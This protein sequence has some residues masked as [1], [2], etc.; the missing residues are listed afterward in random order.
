M[1]LQRLKDSGGETTCPL[2]VEFIDIFQYQ[3]G[4]SATGKNGCDQM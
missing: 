4:Y 3:I 2:T 1:F